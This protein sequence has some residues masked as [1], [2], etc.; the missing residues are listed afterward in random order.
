MAT[1]LKLTITI[2]KGDAQRTR[3]VA[4]DPEDISI[5]L[6]EDLE[7]ASAGGTMSNMKPI[8]SE[9]LGLSNEEY[10]ALT[11]KQFMAIA[12]AIPAAIAEATTI[13]NGQVPPSA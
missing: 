7:Q 12:N 4:I 6:L 10:R 2:G 3:E 1:V 11:V 8:I 9:L 5:G 13:P